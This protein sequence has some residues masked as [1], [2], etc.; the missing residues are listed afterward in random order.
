MSNTVTVSLKD[1]NGNQYSFSDILSIKIQKEYFT[2]YTTAS[3]SV[4]CSQ[5]SAEYSEIS[6][7]IDNHCVHYGLIDTSDYCIK[8]SGTILNVTSKSF[9][10]LLIQNQPVPG[11]MYNTSL[12]SLMESFIDIPHVTHEDNSTV[13]NYIFLKD[14]ANLWDAV[15]NISY[16]ISGI[17]PFVRDNNNIR[18]TAVSAP[19]N[20]TY[21]NDIILSKG[22]FLDY[23]KIISNYH[24]QDIDGNYDTYSL[25]NPAA[26]ARN[27]VR[28][29]QIA[30]DRQYLN[31]PE[32]SM[33]NKL[34][35]SMRGH[36]A[37]Y[38]EYS[39]FSGEDINDTYNTD[40]KIDRIIISGSSEGIKTKIYSY[41]S[42]Q[43]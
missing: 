19:A 22:V 40:K 2:P 6:V 36:C 1:I 12:N 15:V 39:G 28:H 43:S 18:I 14:N 41:K 34:S 42:G 16:K 35:Y 29:K 33:Q 21:S 3:V 13:Q 10:S 25:S 38:I 4:S 17:Y 23:T 9:S 30:L 5:T 24:M 32:Q 27:I 7:Y 37:E 8:P 26:S 31:E 20:F 11:M